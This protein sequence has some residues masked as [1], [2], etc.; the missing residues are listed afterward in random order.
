MVTTQTV[1]SSCS[2]RNEQTNYTRVISSSVINVDDDGLTR[3][4]PP[5]IEVVDTEVSEPFET[6]AGVGTAQVEALRMLGAV[7]ELTAGALVKI[8]NETIY[9]H[10]KYS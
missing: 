7:V 4:D 2:V 6:A 1:A 10:N 5:R 3:A 9:N 8:C